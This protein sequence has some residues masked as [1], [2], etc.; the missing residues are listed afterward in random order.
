VKGEKVKVDKGIAYPTCVTVNN[1]LSGFSPSENDGTLLRE[2][3]MAKIELAAHIDGYAAATTHTI[4][5]G[6]APATDRR[7]D[8][9]A[10]AQN[11]LEASLRLL[12]PG[13]SSNEIPAMVKTVAES[14]GVSAVEGVTRC[15]T[16]KRFVIEGKKEVAIRPKV[17]EKVETFEIEEGEVYSMEMAF[18]T[19]DDGKVSGKD[20]MISV[21]RRAVDVNYMLKLKAA[22]ALFSDINS[23]YPSFPFCMREFEVKHGASAKLGLREMYEHE[24]LHPYPVLV[25]KPEE[26][27]AAFRTT[28]LVLSSGV[29]KL[30]GAEYPRVETD[31]KI[32]DEGVNKLLSSSLKKSKKKKAKGKKEG[33][34]DAK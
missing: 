18:S 24:M 6:G 29:I 28:C 7:A 27:I 21:Y 10:A 2:G 17:D 19:S 4:I 14:Y 22:R 26:S 11:A 20:G 34:G 32:T 5:V 16:L 15:C 1:A 33:A 9:I 3:D 31:K 12:R 30:T 23:Q 8:V 13:M 25:D